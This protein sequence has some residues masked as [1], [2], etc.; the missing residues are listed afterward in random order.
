MR[1]AIRA[2]RSL[3]FPLL[4][5]SS[6][7]LWAVTVPD[8][9]H[10]AAS[11]TLPS[12]PPDTNAVVL[13]T[14]ENNTVISPSEYVEHY[15]H[16]VKILRPDGRNEGRLN[17][18]LGQGEKLLYLHAWTVDKTG[19]EYE[20]K[21]KD[22]AEQ[23]P[24]DSEDFY[25][26]IHFRTLQ[27]PSSEPGSVIALEYE[28]RRHAWHNQ[29]HW[30]LQENIPVR[31]T[32]FSVQIP[33]DWEYKASWSSKTPVEA[34]AMGENR[35]QWTKHDLPALEEEP[36]MPSFLAL[37]E[38]MELAFFAPGENEGNLGSW[39]GLGRWYSVLTTGRRTPTP[40]ITEKVRQLTTNKADFEGKLRALATFMQSDIRYV[41]IEIGI[42]G[43]QPHPASDVYSH[44]Y[45]DC[46]DKATLLSSMLREAGIRSEY[47][48]IDTEHGVVQ[49]SMP[50]LV[51]NH[52]IL[53]VELPTVLN[54]GTPNYH[55][56][57]T[58]K[59][60]KQYLIFDP[61]DPYTS[62]GELRAELQDTNAL[63][64]TD[65][66]G[67]LIHTPL[68]PPETNI[69]ANT[70]RFVL[71]PDGSLS[72]EFAETLSGQHAIHSRGMFRNSNDKQRTEHFENY[73]GNS[74]KNFTLQSTSIEQLDDLQKDLLLNLKFAAPGYAQTRGSL[75]LVRPRV[76][77]EKSFS[78]DHRKPRLYPVE[79][80]GTSK[81]TDV[82]EIEL[83]A[84]Y[85]VDDIPEPVKTDVGFAS[86]QSKFEVT[87]TKLR[88][89]REY[90]LRNIEVGPERMADL[91]KFEGIIGA[92]EAA[93]VVLKKI[94]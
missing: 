48:L 65:S 18:E 71:A 23:S 83:P 11:Q 16:V 69:V 42:G 62:L 66:G 58:T 47:V 19:R 56:V 10:Q 84:G 30:F 54:A 1:K 20:L 4:F 87:G 5:A 53:A 88:Y 2:L 15:R 31:E 77:G 29:V 34:S 45:G 46:K 37:S 68:L 94:P 72:G 92:D 60:G 28:I 25:D 21:E 81:E 26:D 82:Y 41:A 32:R 17:V 90:T 73:L 91:R 9:V 93:S 13:L 80:D 76:L 79:F 35:W 86:Y 14:D 12:Y 63:L 39:N 89:S 75:M 33:H 50:S 57:A 70:G 67:E 64:V 8:W 44:R 7:P 3:C 43:Y 74:L 55:S 59:S 22:F 85:T 49:S 52:V 6:V 51:F 27:A 61:T 40:E 38:R 24:Y 78:L 36:E